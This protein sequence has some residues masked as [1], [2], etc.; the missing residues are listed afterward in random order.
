MKVQ[1][2]IGSCDALLILY[3]LSRRHMYARVDIS[4]LSDEELDPKS[5]ES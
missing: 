5:Q 4:A 2:P 3:K 1:A